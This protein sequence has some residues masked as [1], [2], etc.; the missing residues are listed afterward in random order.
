LVV[1][2]SSLFF[3]NVY[4]FLPVF[5]VTNTA[6]QYRSNVKWCR[7]ILAALSYCCVTL[8]MIVVVYGER[9]SNVE[10]QYC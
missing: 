4:L 7:L 6:V 10:L 8:I 1:F 9:W 3:G 5:V 2:V